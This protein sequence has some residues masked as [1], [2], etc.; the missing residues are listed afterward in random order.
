MAVV[1]VG[2]VVGFAVMAFSLAPAF[3]GR[4]RL[5]LRSWEFLVALSCAVGS[6]LIVVA[7]VAPAKMATEDVHQAPGSVHLASAAHRAQMHDHHDGM[8][9]YLVTLTTSAHVSDNVSLRS[10]S[11]SEK[12]NLH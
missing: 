5:P 10:G 9:R 6:G 3:A 11:K 1:V 12:S 8:G 2:F 7:L 4:H